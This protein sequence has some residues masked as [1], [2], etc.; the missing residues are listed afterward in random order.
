MI[1]GCFRVC[2]RGDYTIDDSRISYI[3]TIGELLGVEAID[4]RS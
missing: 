2:I 4:F 1:G 3:D